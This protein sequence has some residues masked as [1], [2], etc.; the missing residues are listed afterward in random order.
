[1]I[2]IREQEARE[3]EWA[4][5]AQEQET[6]HRRAIWELKEQHEKYIHLMEL[7]YEDHD[8]EARA[9]AEPSYEPPESKIP[10]LETE[11]SEWKGVFEMI[12]DGMSREDP[13]PARLKEFAVSMR[14]K[15]KEAKDGKATTMQ[16]LTEAQIE[17]GRERRLTLRMAKEKEEAREALE[18]RKI[19]LE[20]CKSE[21]SKHTATLSSVQESISA[22]ELARLQQELSKA[23]DKIA[24]FD[25]VRAELEQSYSRNTQAENQ[26]RSLEATVRTLEAQHG[27]MEQTLRRNEA[28]KMAN[29]ELLHKHEMDVAKARSEA[30]ND[31]QRLNETTA[32]L[33]SVHEQLRAKDDEIMGLHNDIQKVQD[34]LS[35]YLL[36]GSSHSYVKTLASSP[37]SKD[38]ALLGKLADAEQVAESLKAELASKE[39]VWDGRKKSYENRIAALESQVRDLQSVKITLRSSS[40]SKGDKVDLSRIQ[41]LI[42]E[43]DEL[44][45]ELTK[46]KENI[47][48]CTKTFDKHESEINSLKEEKRVLSRQCGEL[49]E[50]STVVN[51]LRGKLSEAQENIGKMKKVLLASRE[52]LTV[53]REQH[54]T[55][56]STLNQAIYQLTREEDV[57]GLANWTEPGQLTP[58]QTPTKAHIVQHGQMTPPESPPPLPSPPFHF[59]QL[60][61]VL[62]IS[63]FH[64]HSQPPLTYDSRTGRKREREGESSSRKGAGADGGGLMRRRG[65]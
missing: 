16:E 11:L 40:L 59:H 42:R 44:R 58:S 7:F 9:S 35:R 19:E 31:R 62:F 50:S 23:R 39:G 36:K 29:D 65:N 3:R 20:V 60:V 1:M 2:L 8:Q 47:I 32:R 22:V 51:E 54:E 43:K 5:N 56:A 6:A 10:R 26:I 28:E 24:L 37:P 64:S 4:Y 21:V 38:N 13:T 52:L 12:F 17:L 45:S 18:R 14:G 15:L 34:Q 61:L 63:S 27:K 53:E 55:R 48:L 49:G 41:T 25:P 46:E 57:L 33:S 30:L